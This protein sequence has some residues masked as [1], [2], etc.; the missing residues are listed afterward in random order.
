MKE[1]SAVR[2]ANVLIEMIESGKRA[3]DV[4]KEKG[5]AQISDEAKLKEA[6]NQ[7]IKTN[8]QAVADYKKGKATAITFLVGQLMKATKGKANPA[9]VNKLL[10]EELKK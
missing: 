7:V 5:L 8:P 9:M 6:V 1:R 4:V 3:P 2:L 10:K